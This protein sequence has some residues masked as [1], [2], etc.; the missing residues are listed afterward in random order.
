[1]ELCKVCRLSGELRM[2]ISKY[3][4]MERLAASSGSGAVLV[5]TGPDLYQLKRLQKSVTDRFRNELGYDVLRHYAG[6]LSGGDLKRLLMESSLFASGQ[7]VI[8]SEAHRLGKQSM[9]ELLE[10][11]EGD[12]RDSAVFLTS[13]SVPRQSAVLRKL[14]KLV[15]LY[16]CYEPFERDM[17]L[18][19]SRLASEENIVLKRDAAGLLSQYAGRNL[20]RLAGAVTRLALY[21]GSG[22]VVDGEGVR[23]VLSGKGN[24]DVFHL[25]DMIF[26]GRRGEAL[27]S[28]MG[29]MNMGEEPV[30]IIAYLY[31][32]WQN[33]VAAGEV[34]RLGGGSREVTAATGA[35]YPLL[36]KLMKYAGTYPLACAIAAA[37]AFAE[38]DHLIKTG[39]ESM[40]V[41]A[42]LIFTLTRGSQ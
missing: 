20:R 14:E 15:P 9:A 41:F 13:V 36:D 33:V 26:S 8:I 34:V 35:R 19:T 24:V 25:G 38:A 2:K 18:W 23:E 31:G 7:L 22:A 21:H 4:E 40:V 17:S 27:D 37:E 6:E 39:G 32:L 3:D 11:I 42:D 16:I 12:I 10:A 30:A 1:M 28:A 29:L 5:V